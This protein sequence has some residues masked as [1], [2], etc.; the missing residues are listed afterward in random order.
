[1]DNKL[2][3]TRLLIK[4][5]SPHTFRHMYYL[6]WNNLIN[7]YFKLL[8]L[9]SINTYKFISFIFI[10]VFNPQNTYLINP[11]NST[12]PSKLTYKKL[13]NEMPLRIISKECYLNFSLN[14]IFYFQILLPFPNSPP[15]S[16]LSSIISTLQN[17]LF[18]L[19][20]WYF[21]IIF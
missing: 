6:N 20:F 17:A 18:P 14:L 2:N 16:I 21:L 13:L 7:S 9:Y 3:H 8:R 11:L 19:F 12:I 10:I 15:H 4:T 5:P 1:M